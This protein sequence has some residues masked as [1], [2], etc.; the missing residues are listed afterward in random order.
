MNQ[1]QV[2][3][4]FLRNPLPSILCSRG[5]KKNCVDD[6]L[7]SYGGSNLQKQLHSVHLVTSSVGFDFCGFACLIKYLC[8]CL[9]NLFVSFRWYF[10]AI[11]NSVAFGCFES[12]WYCIYYGL[13]WVNVIFFFFLL[14]LLL[15]VHFCI[16]FGLWTKEYAISYAI[17][18]FLGCWVQF[19]DSNLYGNFCT[20]GC[21][22]L[23][24]SSF[25]LYFPTCFICSV[26]CLMKI[27]ER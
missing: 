20:L 24:L 15:W 12:M 7:L 3:V 8:I 5:S 25:V 18:L 23:V 6:Q 19:Y 1:L 11:S 17:W 16:L 4:L 26:F 22:F 9:G 2:S 10:W 13:V 21:W 27:T 14:L